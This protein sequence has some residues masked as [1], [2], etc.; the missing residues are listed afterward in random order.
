MERTI[1]VAAQNP[2]R[3][4]IWNLPNLITLFRIAAIPFVVLFLFIP[5]APASFLA[6]L[7]FSA[8]SLTDL[9]DGYIARQQNSETPVGKL[10]D[11]L[12][13]KLLINSALI[14]LIPL[15]RVP[16]WVVVLIVGREVAVTGLRGIASLEGLAIAASKWGK[17]KMIFQ[18][19]ALIGLM[20]HYEY[21]GI[22][23]HSLG[24]LI[25][26]IALAITI[27]SGVDYFIKFYREHRKTAEEGKS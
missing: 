14:M 23:F 25:L 13:D 11:P 24:M 1:G 12:A 7:I 8:A 17:A 16:A 20:L 6:A 2:R 21:L 3:P 18:T 4:H 15:G 22:N 26:W 27:W 19:I 9:L 10:L 5:G